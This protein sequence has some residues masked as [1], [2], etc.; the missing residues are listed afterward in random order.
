LYYYLVAS[1]P[2]LSYDA[3]NFWSLEQFLDLCRQHLSARDRRIVEAAS[4]VSLKPVLPTCATLE[5]WRVWEIG[6]RNQLLSLRAKRR[7]ADE[8]R[9]RVQSPEVLAA[10]GVARSAFAQESPLQAEEVLDRARWAH[11]D[12]L[13][14][15]HYFDVDK[16]VIYHLRLQILRRRAL[17]EPAKGAERFTASFE[18]ISRPIYGSG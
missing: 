5:Q 14:V 17:L 6:L 11:L 2:L 13:E 7:G 18:A 8:T 16:V 1:L 12:D 4:L 3:E 9:Y 15:G 10:Q